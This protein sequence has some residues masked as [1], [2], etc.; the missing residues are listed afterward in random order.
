MGNI[1]ND[2]E[3][4]KL[5]NVQIIIGELIYIY[6]IL[7][8]IDNMIQKILSGNYNY[9]DM[10]QKID[11]TELKFRENQYDDNITNGPN[12]IGFIQLLSKIMTK[13]SDDNDRKNIMEYFS[14]NYIEISN[15]VMK[16]I[17][18]IIDDLIQTQKII[19]QQI[20][21]DQL[22]IDKY[23]VDKKI[24]EYVGYYGLNGQE[25]IKMTRLF[26]DKLN[27]LDVILLKLGTV[28]MDC[29]FL[30]R[31]IDKKH[32][33]KNSIIYTGGYHTIVYIWF[34]IKFYDFEIVNYYYLNNEKILKSS[35]ILEQTNIFVKKSKNYNELFEIFF[36]KKFNQCVK[37]KKN[38]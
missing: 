28:F 13:Y 29:F 20:S 11:V 23:V 22:N 18:N 4:N 3:Q 7:I 12:D 10:T 27:G 24:V 38:M 33:I 14:L 21:D 1:L 26:Y 9:D 35:N 15:E 16:Y 8:H 5:L 32:Y 34:L 36:P 30:R 2:I 19:E 25:Y 6:K 31:I 17:K 37:I